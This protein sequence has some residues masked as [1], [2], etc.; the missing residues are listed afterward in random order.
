M[1]GDDLQTQVILNCGALPCLH[2]LLSS[3][4]ETVRKEACWT[5]SNITAGNRQQIQSVVDAN[6]FPILI[7]LMS[8]AEFKTRK[9][10]AWAITNT[11]SGGTPD[12]IRYLVAQGCIGPLCDLLTVMD[13]KI[14][15]VALNGLENIL[16]LGDQDAKEG[17][18]INKYAVMVEECYGNYRICNIIVAMFCNYFCRSR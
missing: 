6:I 11:T 14:V 15:Q 3:V 5:L 4:K 13:I 12:Q 2:H 16:R 1:T 9:E 17:D 10:A 7:D 18:G 8:K